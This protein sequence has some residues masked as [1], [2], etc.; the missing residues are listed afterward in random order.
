MKFS[1]NENNVE[2][3]FSKS[4]A[5]YKLHLLSESLYGNMFTGNV[6]NF[7]YLEN[8]K[9]DQKYLIKVTGLYA[10][11]RFLFDLDLCKETEEIPKNVLFLTT[12]KKHR[13][14]VGKWVF[15]YL[16]SISFRFFLG[17]LHMFLSIFGDRIKPGILLENN[18]FPARNL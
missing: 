9:K 1:Q 13:I 17:N 18:F 7:A 12:R 11:F 6:H 3:S 10:T 8:E 4:A 15:F 2:K 14:R 5:C 16:V